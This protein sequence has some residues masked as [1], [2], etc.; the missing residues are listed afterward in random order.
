MISISPGLA[1]VHLPEFTAIGMLGF[2]RWIRGQYGG[3]CGAVYRLR[4]AATASPARQQDNSSTLRVARMHASAANTLPASR[5]AA[6]STQAYAKLETRHHSDACLYGLCTRWRS[7]KQQTHSALN[8]V[9][10][11]CMPLGSL[12]LRQLET[13]TTRMRALR[14]PRPLQRDNSLTHGVARMHAPAAPTSSA[15]R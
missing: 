8:S 11:G 6:C 10:H 7:H 15:T 12:H 13:R 9:P 14:P 1:V 5:L 4:P 3:D 2:A